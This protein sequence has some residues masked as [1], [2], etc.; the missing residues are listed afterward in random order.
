MGV[1]LKE[2]SPLFAALLVVLSVIYTG[3]TLSTTTESLQGRLTAVEKDIA[4]IRNAIEG[5]QGVL[6]RIATLDVRL[7]DKLQ[8]L[9]VQRDNYIE[10][11]EQESFNIR[12]LRDEFQ[13]VK[14][15]VGIIR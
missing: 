14:N 2:W 5:H 6:V 11:N 10:H 13:G 15:H 7:G 8:N 12:D 3:K 4:S 9:I 1:L